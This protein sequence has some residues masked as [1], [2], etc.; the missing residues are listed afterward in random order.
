MAYFDAARA[1]S[2]SGGVLPFGRVMNCTYF[3][4]LAK[5]EVPNVF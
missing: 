5:K 3:D 1:E 4:K 2:E